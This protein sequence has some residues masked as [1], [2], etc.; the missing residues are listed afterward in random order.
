VN[1]I[2]RILMSEKGDQ[3]S[4]GHLQLLGLWN[5]VGWHVLANRPYLSPVY[6]IKVSV[7]AVGILHR[8]SIKLYVFK[9][10]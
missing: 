2:E 10:L 7:I 5:V 6:T 1:E 3:V 9:N 4:K 8:Y